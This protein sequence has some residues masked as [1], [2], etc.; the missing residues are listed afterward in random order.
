MQHTKDEELCVLFFSHQFYFYKKVI[1]LF[2]WSID[3]F[4]NG[5]LK[6]QSEKLQLERT[7]FS[8]DRL[9]RDESSIH[10]QNCF[11]PNLWNI[12]TQTFDE[13]KKDSNATENQMHRGFFN[14]ARTFVEIKNVCLSSSYVEFHCKRKDKYLYF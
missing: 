3:N 13:G 10:F 5:K 7:H 12:F 6:I 8:V 1:S 14:F 4:S 2:K 11:M 9:G